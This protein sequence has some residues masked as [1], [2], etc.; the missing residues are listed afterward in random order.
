MAPLDGSYRWYNSSNEI[1]QGSDST[2]ETASLLSS[3]IFH[4]SIISPEDCEGPTVEVL[5]E[6]VNVENPVISIQDDKL[7]SSS[8]EGNQ[9]YIDGNIIPGAVDQTYLPTESGFHTVEV[10]IGG[11]TA[12]SADIE[13][14][15]T[16]I[17]GLE[18]SN[19]VK[20]FPNPAN[21]AINIEYHPSSN[22]DIT[23]IIF[24][25][26]GKRMKEYKG[27]NPMDGKYSISTSDFEDGAYLIQLLDGVKNYI[28]RV[29]IN[30]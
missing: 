4:V 13:Y 18:A 10:T 15:I 12:I 2:F 16:G 27:L 14:L 28:N 1:L 21:G 19:V 8:A 30:N 26:S 17:S 9:W 6:V 11:C 24:D 29:I 7:N 20:I 23:I 3:E 5:A 25:L 22:Q